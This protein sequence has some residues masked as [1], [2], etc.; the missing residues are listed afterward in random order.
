MKILIDHRNNIVT[1]TADNGAVKVH[2]D[3]N[4]KLLSAY[5][6]GGIDDDALLNALYVDDTIHAIMDGTMEVLDENDPRVLEAF[7]DSP[8]EMTDE[9]VEEYKAKADQLKKAAEDK[10]NETDR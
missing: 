3:V 4:P 8:T 5:L 1:V 2:R 6:E 7:D 9:K 10:N